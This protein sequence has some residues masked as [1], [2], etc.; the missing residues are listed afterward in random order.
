[1]APTTTTTTLVPT[2]TTTTLAPTTT[3]TTTSELVAVNWSSTYDIQS[4]AN[5]EFRIYEDDILQVTSNNKINSNGTFYISNGDNIRVE[6]TISSC[7][8]NINS[9]IIDQTQTAGGTGTG[10][11]CPSPLSNSCSLISN[12]TTM[13]ITMEVY[14]ATITTTTTTLAPTTTTTTTSES[15]AVNWYSTYN[16]QGAANNVVF[17]IYE[18]GILMVTTSLNDANGVFYCSDGDN[19][20]A[21]AII[22]GCSPS[23]NTAQVELSDNSDTQGAAAYCPSNL[24]DSNSLI[25]DGS[26]MTITLICD[27]VITTTTTTLAPTTTTT[28]LAPTTTTTTLAPTTTTT[29]LAPTTTTTTLAPT[30]TTTTLSPTTTTTTLAPTTTTTT[31]APTTTTTTLAP[32]TTTTTTLITFALISSDDS[33]VSN[34]NPVTVSKNLSSTSKILILTIGDIFG[35][36]RGTTTAPTWNGV[37]MT[38]VGTFAGS[39]DHEIW[40]ITNP[41]TGTHSL[42]IS[43]PNSRSLHLGLSWYS[44]DTNISL[45]DY[46]VNIDT[47][48]SPI[49]TCTVPQNKYVLLVDSV[50]FTDTNAWYYESNSDIIIDRGV[51]NSTGAPISQYA[52]YNNDS[53]N[54]REMSWTYTCSGPISTWHYI[55]AVFEKL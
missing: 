7:T 46:S 11:S 13:T 15:V 53:S 48:T 16:V 4:V 18:D 9:V 25:S 22:S 35:Y 20:T 32:T 45:Y 29:T 12:G 31:L 37:D 23:I 43:N 6:F 47:D 14:A 38:Q 39:Y 54:N 8:P 28:T 40:Y 10:G 42:S 3:T 27:V 1:L 21:E 33:I 50:T 41:D 30:T 51:A 34:S 26:T 24:T 52:L 36:G 19:I 55:I 17:K 2:T 44:S 49:C 5:V